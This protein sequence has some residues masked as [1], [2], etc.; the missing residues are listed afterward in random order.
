MGLS[1]RLHL[2][3]H[4]SCYPFSAVLASYFLDETLNI[5]GKVGCFLSLIGS[6]VLV[7]HAPQ[8]E[9]VETVDELGAKLT[10]AGKRLTSRGAGYQMPWY[11]CTSELDFY[12]WN[13]NS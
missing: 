13:A 4:S 1:L 6:V 10:D 3:K 11:I 7:I 2:F 8:E 9:A 5:H 12:I